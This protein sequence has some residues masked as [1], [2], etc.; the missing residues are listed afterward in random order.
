[1]MNKKKLSKNLIIT[2]GA[3]ALL[4]VLN[5]V[6][7]KVVLISYGS[8]VNG[9]LA[10]VNQ[11]YSYIALLEAGIGTATVTALYAPLANKNKDEIN[12]VCSASVS[13]YRHIL[14]WYVL[15][16][17]IVSF[18]WPFTLE[19]TIGYGTI[20]GV[21]LI[22]G[23]SNALTF[24]YVSTTTNYLVASG[25]NYINA[26]IHMGITALTYIS[27]AVVSLVGGNVLIV[28][29]TLLGINAIKCLIY[30]IYKKIV[31]KNLLFNLKADLSI[32]KQRNSFLIH[33]I[34]GV[35]FSSTDL[36]L[37]S[38]LCDLKAASIY[39]VYSMVVSAV[40]TI[41][42]QVFNSSH[43]ILGDAYHKDNYQKTHDNFNT[44]YITIV[45]ALYTIAYIL[46]KP[47]IEIYTR[48]IEDIDYSIRFL[49][50]LFVLIQLLS[51][52]RAVDT[53]LIR[54]AGHAK[55]TISRTIIEAVVNLGTSIL[56]IGSIGIHGALLGTIL[57]LLYRANDMIIY[58]NKRILKRSPWKEYK[59]Y[60]LNFLIFG[61]AVALNYNFPIQAVGYLDLLG[62]AVVI[63]IIVIIVYCALNIAIFG[64]QIIKP[65]KSK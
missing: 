62:K 58:A 65:L 13:Y 11:V 41:I 64:K 57:A 34:V 33:E 36:V 49:P 44:I 47:F 45:F 56:L 39:A 15:C 23:V 7:S 61:F 27:K 10:S 14:K 20:F 5:I 1:M 4:L 17:I 25:K 48:G 28:S 19:S 55:L 24:Y 26:Y 51:A 37:I 30:G 53:V 29:L 2:F 60:L 46:F 12:H 3:Y 43:Y 32:L 50:I 22:Q 40:S 59:L 18:L 52:C 63:S 21:I 16:V 6:V 38:V 54:N 8:E 31:C 35:V 9:L 42:G